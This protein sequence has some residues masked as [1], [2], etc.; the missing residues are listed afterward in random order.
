[1]QNESGIKNTSARVNN[2]ASKTN[3]L[4]QLKQSM[5]H[6]SSRMSTFETTLGSKIDRLEHNY[7]DLNGKIEDLYGKN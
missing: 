6:L 7:S 1:M 3:I 2:T 4:L 5:D